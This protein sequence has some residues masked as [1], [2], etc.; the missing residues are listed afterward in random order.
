MTIS[1]EDAIIIGTERF[2]ENNK[3]RVFQ[4]IERGTQAAAAEIATSVGILVAGKVDKF[5]LNNRAELLAA[6]QE[7]TAK[8]LLGNLQR[9]IQVEKDPEGFQIPGKKE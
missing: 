3:E 9:K 8:A 2:F 4:A 6:F 5:M 7:M 1:K